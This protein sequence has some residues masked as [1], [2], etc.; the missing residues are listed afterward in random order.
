ME[1]D[2]VTNASKFVRAL[3][4]KKEEDKEAGSGSD[5][6]QFMEAI[7]LIKEEKKGGSCGNCL[8]FMQALTPSTEEVKE[9]GSSG[10]CFQFMQA[11]QWASISA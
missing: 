10:K 11:H 3:T 6:F 1:G 7:T 4:P 5:C 2:L 8:Q 9:G